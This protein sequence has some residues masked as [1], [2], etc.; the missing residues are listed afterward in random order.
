MGK[1]IYVAYTASSRKIGYYKI[2]ETRKGRAIDRI[3]EYQAG[4]K[5]RLCAL[6]KNPTDDCWRLTKN[7]NQSIQGDKDIHK[8]KDL[9]R[10]HDRTSGGGTEWF[11]F[12]SILK[13]F[14]GDCDKVDDFIRATINGILHNKVNSKT[15]S[16]YKYQKTIIDSISKKLKRK[17][18]KRVLL[19]AVMRAGKCFI[20]YKTIQKMGYKNVLVVTSFPEAF[21][22]WNEDINHVDFN[23]FAITEVVKFN[24][25]T[26]TP[27]S[28]K[29]NVY[30]SSLQD[31]LGDAKNAIEGGK[32]L[33]EYKRKHSNFFAKA[34]AIDL[35]ILDEC[36]H[37]DSK[38]RKQFFDEIMIKNKDVKFL[39]LSGTP[40]KIL[41]RK[42][43]TDDEQVTYD[44]LSRR[45]WIAEMRETSPIEY[46]QLG[47][48]YEPVLNILGLNLDVDE[49]KKEMDE[50]GYDSD[51]GQTLSKLFYV[52]KDSTEFKNKNAVKSV[53][54]KLLGKHNTILPFN[55]DNYHIKKN[56]TMEETEKVLGKLSDALRCSMW[57]FNNV[58]SCEAMGKLINEQY[59]DDFYPV[60]VAGDNIDENGKSHKNSMIRVEQAI[61][62]NPDKK[63][64]ILS[65]GKLS[66][67]VTIPEIGAVLNFTEGS[68]VEKYFQTGFRAMSSW[69]TGKKTDAFVID[70][71]PNRAFSMTDEF[72]DSQ[73]KI[74][75]EDRIPYISQH[76][77][78]YMD[79]TNGWVYLSGAE[80]MK[81][82]A[83]TPKYS[84]FTSA[85]DFMESL[86]NN[87]P[88]SAV[89]TEDLL[90]FS[91]TFKKKEYKEVFSNNIDR[92][93][94]NVKLSSP[95]KSQ[96]E[97]EKE[98]KN[99][100]RTIFSNFH[101]YMV[102]I[103]VSDWDILRNRKSINDTVFMQYIGFD[104]TWFFKSI[105]DDLKINTN[106]FEKFIDHIKIKCD[107]VY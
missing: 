62:Q 18:T 76:I 106:T 19:N 96:Q 53:L 45:D 94:N 40:I 95:V 65:C 25:D 93:K 87:I 52:I 99:I 77:F 32:A 39:F 63:I 64:I 29:V 27:D 5:E 3:R 24:D 78:S 58:S 4:E 42:E 61:V 13:Q 67:G 68:S 21:N 41:N 12:S 55:C 86:I 104:S 54:K 71:A 2:G 103:R 48:Q 20:S 56:D 44:Y 38:N 6:F 100:L 82:I 85:D 83:A 51:S 74:N 79:Y 57:L 84:A 47:L 30:T 97:R 88:N 49:I 7:T 72:F 10:F 107:I 22:S 9:R 70:F 46:D 90:K 11:D 43:F 98:I 28:T 91:E 31:F 50:Y 60:I 69:K 15:H 73:G 66:T 59:S 8:H 14:N 1:K 17:K 105:I 92:G 34:G 35:I 36:H 16:P 101:N 80:L 89:L 75:S 102:D 23:N 26:F 33:T 37:Y 81:S